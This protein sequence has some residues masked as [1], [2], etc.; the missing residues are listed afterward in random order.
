MAGTGVSSDSATRD[1]SLAAVDEKLEVVNI[2]VSDVERAKEFYVGLGWRLD[3]DFSFDDGFR[4]V[5]ITPPGSGASI[6]FGTG[7]TES[8]P[9]AAQDM[10]LIVSDIEAARAD[11][12]RRGAEVGP[13]FH[14]GKPGAR[15]RQHAADRVE[16]ASP[17]GSYFT[18]AT[19]S[20]PDGNSWL[21]QEITTRLAG[22]IDTG[23]TSYSSASDLQAALIRAA[24][25]HG[26]HEKRTGEAD[27]N[28]PEWYA[29]YMVAEQDGTELPR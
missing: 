1:P 8:A 6:A 16:G 17:K 19:F 22:R 25:A 23:V 29:R 21:L 20:D 28:W 12:N 4:I 10:Y 11:L 7:V 26:E 27:P 24:T 15:F 9:G 3:A 5:Q 18:F 14:E 13:A 2:P